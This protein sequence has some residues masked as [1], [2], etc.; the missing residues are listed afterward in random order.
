M[1]NPQGSGLSEEEFSAHVQA[2]SAEISTAFCSV[3]E[4]YM[5]DLCHEEGA[6]EACISC[7]EKALQYDPRNV[8]A[9]QVGRLSPLFDHGRGWARPAAFDTDSFCCCCCWN[10]DHG[11]PVAK[12]AAAGAG[13]DVA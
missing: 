2:C 7:A 6:Q 8:Q 4:I 12:P 11:E 13:A 9:M 3:A 5:S 10:A 1:A